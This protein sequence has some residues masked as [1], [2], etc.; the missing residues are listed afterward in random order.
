MF[1]RVIM[2]VAGSRTTLIE[3]YPAGVVVVLRVGVKLLEAS[4]NCDLVIYC[5]R[6][7]LILYCIIVL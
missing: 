1:E 6:S 2:I 7:V 3:T 5:V 4:T